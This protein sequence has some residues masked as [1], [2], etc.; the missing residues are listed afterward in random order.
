MGSHVHSTLPNY[1]YIMLYT[2]LIG[3]P[4]PHAFD[5]L[6]LY[7]GEVQAVCLSRCFCNSMEL[8]EATGIYFDK[9]H[10]GQTPTFV[11]GMTGRLTHF[12]TVCIVIHR[13]LPVNIAMLRISQSICTFERQKT[14]HHESTTTSPISS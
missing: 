14:Y 10:S 3:S 1:K 8:N 5:S 11:S 9:H 13:T 2:Y 7:R 4:A 6:L 12:A